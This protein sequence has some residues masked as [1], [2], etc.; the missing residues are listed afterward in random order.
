MALSVT[1]ADCM[2][3]SS[4][5]Q[6]S[7][8]FRSRFMPAKACSTAMRRLERAAFHSR[9]SAVSFTPVRSQHVGSATESRV[10]EKDLV[11]GERL[12]LLSQVKHG[13]VVP[14]APDPAEE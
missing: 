2:A 4:P 12:G 9:R 8:T 13:L 6:R 10:A 14:V 3:R 11:L 7:D 1:Q 5:R